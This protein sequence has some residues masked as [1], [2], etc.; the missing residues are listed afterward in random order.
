MRPPVLDQYVEIF[1]LT[2]VEDAGGGRSNTPTSIG[3]IWADI[4]ETRGWETT[5]ADRQTDLITYDVLIRNEGLGASLTTQDQMV[6]DGE[7]LN[8]RMAPN[9]GRS[10]FRKLRCQYGVINR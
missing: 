4:K 5:I 6:W 1:R 8:I 9:A 3:K 2:K 10:N 7:T